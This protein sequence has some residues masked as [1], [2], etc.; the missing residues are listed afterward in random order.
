MLANRH[1]GR[2][3]TIVDVVCP[4][5]RTRLSSNLR[6]TSHSR[7]CGTRST[8][9]EHEHKPQAY[10]LTGYYADMLLLLSDTP[11][12]G[13]IHVEHFTLPANQSG[14]R[15]Q[16]PTI[17][18]RNAAVVA[19]FPPAGSTEDLLDSGSIIVNGVPVPPRPQE[20]DN[21]CMSGCAH[22]VWDEFR[23]DLENWLAKVKE[24]RK[25]A[26]GPSLGTY[27]ANRPGSEQGSYPK[28][29]TVGASDGLDKDD[30]SSEGAATGGNTLD[31]DLTHNENRFEDIPVGILEFMR[32]EKKMKEKNAG[33]S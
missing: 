12:T 6:P 15:S 7:A 3:R 27:E 29:I 23:E 26:P 1:I 21:C 31:N 19:E 32:L 22:C 9:L 5:S 4:T 14:I 33:H 20:P 28:L 13:E 16:L 17:H 25:S 30:A 11:Q 24:A 8:G 10:P 18:G 2:R